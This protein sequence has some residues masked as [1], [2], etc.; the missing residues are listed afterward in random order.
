MTSIKRVHEDMEKC[1]KTI[2][3]DTDYIVEEICV[4]GK[5]ILQKTEAVHQWLPGN[6]KEEI[7]ALA[8]TI[9]EEE[10]EALPHSLSENIED[11]ETQPHRLQEYILLPQLIQAGIPKEIAVLQQLM[12][13]KAME[14]PEKIL[15]FHESQEEIEVLSQ[16][17]AVMIVTL[18]QGPP[19]QIEV[20][21]QLITE[22]VKEENIIDIPLHQ[23]PEDIEV[24]SQ[25]IPQ[26]IIL[27]HQRITEIEALV[28]HILKEM[29]VVHQ[30]IMEGA[31]EEIVALHQRPEDI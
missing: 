10:E 1:V 13:Q 19:F 17:I 29:K 6:I 7:R 2:M 25:R 5:G 22:E 30:L 18:L 23:S 11:T 20:I 15:V 24:L 4:L 14:A 3:M 16:R 27:A 31:L 8:Q 28:P 12:L 9:P 26:I 21:H